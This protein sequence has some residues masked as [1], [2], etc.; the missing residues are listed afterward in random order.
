METEER[1]FCGQ[2]ENFMTVP[3]KEL[4]FRKSVFV[5]NA[6]VTQGSPHCNAEFHISDQI[7]GGQP[8]SGHSMMYE[9]NSSLLEKPVLYFMSLNQNLRK[10]LLIH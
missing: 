5:S 1:G 7:I 9:S 3:T 4:N 2:T 10:D 8:H 6:I